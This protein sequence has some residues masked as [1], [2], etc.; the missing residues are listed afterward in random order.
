MYEFSIF[1]STMILI[2]SPA[3]TQD[4]TSPPLTKKFTHSRCESETLALV[5]ELQQYSEKKL[6]KLMSISEK[7]A[8]LN[9]ERYQ[10]FHPQFTPKNS[11]PALLAFQGDV[12][13][14]IEVE[15]Y[16]E[17]DFEFAQRH[18]RILS[19]LYGPLRPLDLIQPY[20]LEMKTKLKTKKGKDLYEFWGDM[21]TEIL[22][23]DLMAQGDDVLVNL[24]SNEYAKIV[25]WKKLKGRVI[26]VFFKE[27]KGKNEPKIIPLFSKRA[28]GTMSNFVIKNRLSNPADL[29]NFHE[30]GYKFDAKSSDEGSLVFVRQA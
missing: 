28:R 15:K 1:S 24:A 23:E 9:F 19:G 14:D 6:A 17:A 22:N 11:R 21:V 12:Y 25:N 8:H 16:S 30:Q 4:F 26:S 7:L 3:K 18:L 2:I 5:A 13:T 27:K 29:K 20:R 10:H